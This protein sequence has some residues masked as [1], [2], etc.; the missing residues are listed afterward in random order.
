MNKFRLENWKKFSAIKRTKP[1]NRLPWGASGG[2]DAGYKMKGKR[3]ALREKG[4]PL[5]LVL[6]GDHILRVQ[7]LGVMR[8]HHP[9]P[10]DLNISG[11]RCGLGVMC[12]QQPI[13]PSCI[14]FLKG[15]CDISSLTFH[16]LYPLG[17][18]T[19]CQGQTNSGCCCSEL[20]LMASVWNRDESDSWTPG[21]EIKR[22][23]QKKRFL[24]ETFVPGL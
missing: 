21:L 10:R 5:S 22:F 9:S 24:T 16:F 17:Q 15:W 1:W 18:G 19:L 6:Q 11:H 13:H 20:I 4:K 12:P 14:T 2:R 8:L 23:L 3:K 7:D